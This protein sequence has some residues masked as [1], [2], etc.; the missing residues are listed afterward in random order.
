MHHAAERGDLNVAKLLIQKGVNINCLDMAGMTPLHIGAE[1]G[2]AEFCKLLIDTCKVHSSSLILNDICN[3]KNK[4]NET[5]LFFAAATGREDIVKLF[6]NNGAIIKTDEKCITTPIH[7]A[8]AS[9]SLE[10][11]KVLLEASNLLLE[12]RNCNDETPLHNAAALNKE[13]ILK[14]FIELGC[15]L[16][17]IDKDMETP[18]IAAAKKDNLNIVKI[19]VEN[20]ANVMAKDIND[21]NCLHWCCINNSFQSAEYLLLCTKSTRLLPSEIDIHEN[22]ALHM[23]AE[24]GYVEMCQLLL[25]NDKTGLL[26]NWKNDQGYTPMLLAAKYGHVKVVELFLNIS[27]TLLMDNDDMD[28]SGLHLSASA[29]QV[30]VTKLLLQRGAYI[31]AKNNN[32]QT[33]LDC[34]ICNGHLKVTK[35]II[36][37]DPMIDPSDRTHTTPLMMA[38]KL[39]HHEIVSL[40][41]ESGSDV[42]RVDNFQRNCLDIAIDENQRSSAIVLLKSSRWKDLLR[43]CSISPESNQVTSPMRKLIKKMPDVAELVFDRCIS[44]NGLPENHPKYVINLDYEFLEDVATDWGSAIPGSYFNKYK[45][46]KNVLTN[47]KNLN[48]SKKINNFKRFFLNFL[49]KKDKVDSPH[50]LLLMVKKERVTLL[51]HPLVAYL[52]RYKWK[53]FG[54][55][56]YYFRLIFFFLY[57]IFLTG[58][59]LTVDNSPS[60]NDCQNKNLDLNSKLSPVFVVF[61]TLFLFIMAFINSFIKIVNFIFD[62][63]TICF[64]EIFD[65]FASLITMFYVSGSFHVYS[66]KFIFPDYRCSN[67]FRSVGAI[68][69]WMSYLSFVLFMR[70]LPKVGIYVVMYT[71]IFR[72]FVQFS[73]IYFIII[74]SYGFSF[75]LLFHQHSEVEAYVTPFRSIVKTLLGTVGEI[76]YDTFYNTPSYKPLFATWILLIAFI[77]TNTLILMNLLVGL[78]VDDIQ[79]V[80][81]KAVLKRLALQVF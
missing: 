21:Y 58:Y 68:S 11:V 19:L 42:L 77:I 63:R 17:C 60:D 4:N 45:I 81:S 73:P 31:D 1:E 74:L 5:P 16:N 59:S 76:E 62:Y 53:K 25:S 54:R 20:K 26:M 13:N 36:N 48:E 27:P 9:G 56:V 66:G 24:F 71:D 80:Q 41:L 78:A 34:S 50:P 46:E 23:A 18:L 40:L 15:D 6:L 75:Y 33:P 30:G 35:T 52:L 61:G 67:T 79:G 2:H 28:N 57:L 32:Q 7:L 10:T 64:S 70:K 43:N 47:S 38:C 72:T 39:G 37:Y 8:C 65:L 29:G 55:H 44:D 22:T 3:A 12:A 14:Y 51:S 69:M 49:N